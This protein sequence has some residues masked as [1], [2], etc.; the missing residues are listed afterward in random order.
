[1]HN[2]HPVTLSVFA[3]GFLSV[4]CVWPLSHKIV[5]YH[6]SDGLVAPHLNVK[7][8][9]LPF[10]AAPPQDLTLQHGNKLF[11][12]K[13]NTVSSFVRHLNPSF[14]EFLPSSNS[15]HPFMSLHHLNIFSSSIP[16][17]S[18]SRIS[19]G[20]RRIWEPQVAHLHRLFRNGN[21]KECSQKSC[22]EIILCCFVV[23]IAL[24]TAD[25]WRFYYPI[26]GPMSQW[27]GG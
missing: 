20:T 1:M 11:F 22:Q 14:F 2:M 23:N 19:H 26:M 21:W 9:S 13:S 5:D 24:F 4:T 10:S 8:P 15:I 25:E 16:L 3:L 18:L 27:R 17:Q 7:P 6:H 12:G